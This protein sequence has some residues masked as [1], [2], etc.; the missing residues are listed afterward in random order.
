MAQAFLQT[1]SGDHSGALVTLTSGL[2]GQGTVTGCLVNAAACCAAL[3][4][5]LSALDFALTGVAVNPDSDPAWY[6]AVCAAVGAGKAGEAVGLAGMAPE[7]VRKRSR[8]LLDEDVMAAEDPFV[9]FITRVP[10]LLEPA[11][12]KYMGLG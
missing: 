2:A 4:S 1:Q 3:G 12:G 9:T 10:V 8:V 11:K 7:R 5:H 6:R